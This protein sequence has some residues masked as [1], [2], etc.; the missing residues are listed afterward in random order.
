MAID[1]KIKQK[2]EDIR[3]KK[4]GIEVRESL[5]SGLEAISEDVVGTINRQNT[6]EETLQ[7][8]ID[9]TTGKDVISAPEIIAARVDSKGISYPNIKTR[10]DNFEVSTAQQLQ[11]TRL[12]DLLH[13]HNSSDGKIFFRKR[14]VLDFSTIVPFA[15]STGAV[16]SFKRPP[17]AGEEYILFQDGYVSDLQ[18]TKKIKSENYVINKDFDSRTGDYYDIVLGGSMANANNYA[19]A[20][21]ATLTI[22]FNGD[23]IAFNNYKRDNG[24]IWEF[25]LDGDPAKKKQVSVYSPTTINSTTDVLFSGLEK[26]THTLVG[27]FLG[28]DPKNPP[29]SG[30]GTARGWFKYSSAGRFPE[31]TFTVWESEQEEANSILETKRFD[32]L[33]EHSNKEFAIRVR[34]SGTSLPTQFFPGHVTTA[35]TFANS[36]KVLVDGEEVRD[37]TASDYEE[38]QVVQLIQ[39]MRGIYPDTADHVVNIYSV[40]T[41]TSKGVSVKVNIDFLA[42]LYC[43]TG[44]SL[45]FPVKNSFA[46][47]LVT[48]TGL[49]YDSVKTDG[50][51]TDIAENDPI[52]Y[53]FYA[54]SGTK[55]EQDTL[56]A[57][58]VQNPE[59]TYRAGKSGRRVPVAWLQHRDADMQK[60]YIQVYQDTEIKA[61]ERL[62]IGGTFYIGALPNAKRYF[63]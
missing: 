14:G 37:W 41:I 44:Y 39:D 5:A 16:Y 2:A 40:H 29:A 3:I 1:P 56:V 43:T 62:S 25:V 20:A 21:G 48:S 38:C 28:D 46:K 9:N 58:D 19:G 27:T 52:S 53:A 7:Q 31:T 26:K 33:R 22:T 18:K 6:V 4:K 10:I 59:R 23:Y 55:G 50:S 15:G 11:Q 60:V 13:D 45:M 51:S 49:T 61:G 34:P 12:V 30:A 42:D 63:D 57:M 35:T 24:G 17:I 47:R 32:V 36:Q 8:V 54:N